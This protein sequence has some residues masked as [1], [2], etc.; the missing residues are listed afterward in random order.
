MRG[1]LKIMGLTGHKVM[2]WDTMDPATVEEAIKEFNYRTANRYLGYSLDSPG[3]GTVLKSFDPNA[4]E[5]I[6]ALPLVG[7]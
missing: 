3:Q 4:K 7:G 2:D 1:E 5:I 6:M